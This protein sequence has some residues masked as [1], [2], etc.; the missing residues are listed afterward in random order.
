MQRIRIDQ[1]LLWALALGLT[2]LASTVFAGAKEIRGFTLTVSDLD[3]AVGFYQQ[4]L[5]FRKVEEQTVADPQ[6]D[7]LTGVFGTRVRNVTFISPRVVSV[8]GMPWSKG[9]MVKDPDGHAVLL[10]EP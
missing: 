4:A 1:L 8:P 9:L 7:Y 6:F 2:L 10:V 5:G 3:R